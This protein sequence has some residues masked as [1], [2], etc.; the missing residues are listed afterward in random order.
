MLGF[1][2]LRDGKDRDSTAYRRPMARLIEGELLAPQVSAMMDLSDG[3]LLDANRMADAS[4]VTLA[5]DSKAVPLATMPGRFD[6]AIRWGDDYELLFTLPPG[7][8]PPVPA[9]RI[10]SVEPRGFVP[11]FLDGEP[12]ANR[13]GLGWEH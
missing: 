9:T 5:I 13:D 11:L 2:S 6:A 8:E 12:I 3:L 7:I 1:E 4:A 10:G